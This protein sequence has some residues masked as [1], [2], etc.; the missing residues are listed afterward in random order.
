MKDDQRSLPPEGNQ[1]VQHPKQNRQA[2]NWYGNLQAHS[3]SIVKS[4]IYK[5]AIDSTDWAWW[6]ESMKS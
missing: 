5:I 2:P 3:A 4:P 6:L 1:S